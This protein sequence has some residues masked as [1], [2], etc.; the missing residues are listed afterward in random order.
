MIAPLRSVLSLPSF[1][2]TQAKRIAIDNP[3]I[4]K[5]MQARR[6]GDTLVILR[7]MGKGPAVFLLFTSSILFFNL[8]ARIYFHPP[9]PPHPGPHYTPIISLVIGIF[10]LASG[11][12]LWLL[13]FELI[14][15]HSGVKFIAHPISLGMNR[16]VAAQEIHDLKL[17]QAG[18]TKSKPTYRLTYR[19]SNSK[20]RILARFASQDQADFVEQSIREIVGIESD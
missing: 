4:P 3:S 9:H 10:Y 2:S 17:S 14:I 15:S 8:G 5:G 13:T 20:E 1:S 18:G 12:W 19:D 16:S 6:D 7:R 11:L